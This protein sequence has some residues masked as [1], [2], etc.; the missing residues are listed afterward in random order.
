MSTRKNN[1]LASCEPFL[2]LLSVNL[3]K[4]KKRWWPVAIKCLLSLSW[5]YFAKQ[6]LKRIDAVDRGQGKEFF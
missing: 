2:S 4:T 1:L 3:K 6:R 5:P